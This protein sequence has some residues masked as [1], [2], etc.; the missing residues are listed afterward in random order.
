MNHESIIIAIQKLNQ[1]GKKCFIVRLRDKDYD[2]MQSI[3]H[4]G[5]VFYHSMSFIY[6]HRVNISLVRAKL[7]TNL[8]G[9][10]RYII[11]Q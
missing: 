8:V 4:A 1:R 2:I 10:R 5:F 9:F 3:M 11:H 6:R 7:S